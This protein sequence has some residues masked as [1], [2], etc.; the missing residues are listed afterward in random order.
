MAEAEQVFFHAP[1]LP[2]EDATHSQDAPCFHVLAKTDE[3]RT[4]HS[5]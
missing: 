3:D 1:L 5:H 4:L 2:L